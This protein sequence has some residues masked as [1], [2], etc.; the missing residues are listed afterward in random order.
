VAPHLGVSFKPAANVVS[1][2]RAISI[3]VW[4]RSLQC[5]G[6]GRHSWPPQVSTRG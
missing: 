1:R 2:P 4:L 6:T 3:P 5:S